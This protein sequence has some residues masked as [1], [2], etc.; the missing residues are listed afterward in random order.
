[1]LGFDPSAGSGLAIDTH[2]DKW[3]A[4]LARNGTNGLMHSVGL[5]RLEPN[6]VRH[7]VLPHP[8][9]PFSVK[10]DRAGRQLMTATA[11]QSIRFWNA[12]QGTLARELPFPFPEAVGVEVSL[13]G[14]TAVIM[15]RRPS[16]T[17]LRLQVVNLADGQIIRS[18]LED[19]PVDQ[20]AFSP[21]GGRLVTASV[22]SAQIWDAV[23]GQPLTKVFK[24]GGRLL[25]VDWSPDGRRV[26]T[27]G[28]GDM[29]MIWDAATGQPLL[30]PMWSAGSRKAFFSHDGR[31]IEEW[32]TEDS[33]VRLWDATTTE[34]VT[35]Q[36]HQDAEL[37]F[38]GV[39]ANQ[40][41][42]V[43]TGG[44]FHSRELRPVSLSMPDAAALA[45]VLSG[46]RL[47]SA[48]VMRAIAPGELA[49]LYHSLQRRAPEFLVGQ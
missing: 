43:L 13:D 32:G 2:G 16:G 27:A 26:V 14:R 15:C 18:P 6:Q 4:V 7:F 30:A 45:Q 36:W 23:T 8:Q 41:F 29:A 34:V 20:F 42:V 21:E 48:G 12:D 37:Q 49:N 1:M 17:S 35:Q 38:A 19:L 3:A 28:L 10:F 24:P 39:T 9:F 40:R 46:R 31:F 47:D 44:V 33:H 25:S 22:Q 5:W 11:G